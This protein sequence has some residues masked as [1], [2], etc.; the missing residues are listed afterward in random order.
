[1]IALC[2]PC[3]RHAP[4][5]PAHQPPTSRSS[6]G[7]EAQREA[8][9]GPAVEGSGEEEGGQGGVWRCVR[10]AAHRCV[11]GAR[12]QYLHALLH[13]GMR[14]SSQ[15]EVHLPPLPLP[16]LIAL[17]R[18][19]YSARV[20]FLP[21]PLSPH[22]TLTPTNL[23][24]PTPTT[25]AASPS[26]HHRAPVPLSSVRL[27]PLTL[28]TRLLSAVHLA[29][30]AHQWMLPSLHHAALCYVAARLRATWHDPVSGG[31][32]ESAVDC[33][34]SSSRSSTGSAADSGTDWA[35]EGPVA[36]WAAGEAVVRAAWAA[37]QWEM[38]GEAVSS[39]APWYPAMRRTACLHRLPPQVQSAVREAHVRLL[40]A[41]P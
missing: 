13:C 4:Q 17:L 27:P 10:V 29:S 33:S 14:E 36:P 22:A 18:F 38:V 8:C 41:P 28:T 23:N 21:L 24:H 7:G 15:H 11:L 19:L 34:D 39:L 35:R 16:A 12:S 37:G 31:P 2:V 26:W 25:A 20:S 1:D 40:T 3:A 5:S 9:G 30:L 6:R 32:C